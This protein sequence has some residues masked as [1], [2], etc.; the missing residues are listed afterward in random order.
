M[1]IRVAETV[2]GHVGRGGTAT[3]NSDSRATSGVGE[4][5]PEAKET[6]WSMKTRQMVKIMFQRML[7]ATG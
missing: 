4:C 2:R 7:F 6:R 3:H 1:N 5:D